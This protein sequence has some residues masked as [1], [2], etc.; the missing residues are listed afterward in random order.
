[1]GVFGLTETDFLPFARRFGEK[2]VIEKSIEAAVTTLE[3][4]AKPM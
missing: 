4:R 2:K 3:K 1:M